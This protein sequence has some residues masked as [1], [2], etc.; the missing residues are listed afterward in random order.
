MSAEAVRSHPRVRKAI[1]MGEELLQR[2]EVSIPDLSKIGRR[3]RPSG[4]SI[5]AIGICRHTQ[6]HI[7]GTKTLPSRNERDG[8]IPP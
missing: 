5:F 7:A 8:S 2:E 6:I 1:Q 3:L 4:E